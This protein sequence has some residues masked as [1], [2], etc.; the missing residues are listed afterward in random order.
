[1]KE[2]K[3]FFKILKGFGVKIHPAVL[4]LIILLIPLIV[5]IWYWR[6]KKKEAKQEQTT[7]EERP[8]VPISG[9]K[10]RKDALTRIWNRF[11]REIPRTFQRS[12]QRF[13]PIVVLGTSGSGKSAL[14]DSSTDWQRQANQFLTQYEQDVDLKIYLGSKTVLQEIS[15]SLLNDTSKPTRQ[16]ILRLWKKLFKNT[17]PTV[18]V[19]MSVEELGAL[20]P[21]AREKIAER[22]RGKLNLLSW[23]HGGCV[24]VRLAITGMDKVQGYAEFSA[25][26]KNR[27]IPTVLHPESTTESSIQRAFDECGTYLPIALSGCTADEFKQVVRYL[28]AAPESFRALSEVLDSLLR[29]ES[30]SYLPTL[31]GIYFTSKDYPS[32]TNN[33]LA[34]GSEHYGLEADAPLLRHRRLAAAVTGVMIALLVGL[35]SYERNLWQR[36]DRALEVLNVSKVTDAAAKDLASVSNFTGVS[37][38]AARDVLVPEFLGVAQEYIREEASKIILETKIKP[39]YQEALLSSDPHLKTLYLQGLVRASSS[40]AMG[41]F[42][43][44]N[45]DDW[46]KASGLPAELIKVYIENT[47]EPHSGQ[48]SEKTL[49]TTFKS[50]GI[51]DLEKWSLAFSTYRELIKRNKYVTKSQ[52]EKHKAIGSD[53]LDELSFAKRFRHGATI[54]TLLKDSPFASDTKQYQMFFPQ[55]QQNSLPPEM[56]EKIGAVLQLFVGSRFIDLQSPPETLPNL[57]GLIKQAKQ[58]P[59]AEEAEPRSWEFKIQDTQFMIRN[60]DWYAIMKTSRIRHIVKS[61]MD[62]N[63]T[64]NGSTFFSDPT[65]YSAVVLNPTNNGNS[66]FLGKTQVEGIYTHAAFNK[67]IRPAIMEFDQLLG[68]VDLAPQDRWE[69][70]QFIYRKMDAYASEYARQTLNYYHSFRLNVGSVEG[71]LVAIKQILQPVSPYTTFLQFVHKNTNINFE[72]SRTEL[73]DPMVNALA[74]FRSFNT[75]MKRT[76]GVYPEFDKYRAILDQLHSTLTATETASATEETS[77]TAVGLKARLN[78]VGSQALDTLMRQDGTYLNIVNQWVNSVGIVKEL[79][80]PFLAPIHQLYLVGLR[81]LETTVAKIWAHDLLPSIRPVLRK[82][83]FDHNGTEEVDPQELEAHLHPTLGRFFQLVDQYVLPVTVLK[84]GEYMAKPSLLRRLHLPSD[85]ITA[86]NNTTR[87]AKRLWDSEGNPKDLEFTIEPVPFGPMVKGQSDTLTL[88][89]LS[90]GKNSL[91]NINQKPFQSKVNLDWTMRHVSQ[92]GAQFTDVENRQPSYP[93]PMVTQD[94]YWS[95]YELLKQARDSHNTWSWDLPIPDDSRVNIE[96]SFVLYENPWTLFEILPN[97]RKIVYRDQQ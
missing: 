49:P 47:L 55:I 96:A 52:L 80:Q 72:K 27:A 15:A 68:A 4:K 19:V 73:F 57:I 28:K 91:V 12:L 62:H 61:F 45:L 84:G 69:L 35:Y 48:L 17:P 3:A 41:L 78:P 54:L 94:S 14:I 60:I 21:D 40:N 42:V 97:T 33:P 6:K 74:R 39:A 90:W 25:F 29:P 77:T 50:K 93:Q 20:T 67:E 30:L 9:V 81:E 10:M 8:V 71:L 66:L 85:M 64:R 26:T 59:S 34:A 82:F 13:K 75:V 51:E 86:L 79:R 22:I 38:Y 76:D 53:L 1:M 5:G 87:L 16:A 88:V 31:G 2:L 83:P 37:S 63:A 65:Q 56:S 92:L 24:E 44:Q 43:S 32:N 7:S 18:V 58:Y 95:F 36:A 89:Y 23:A 46:Q 70:K 11:L